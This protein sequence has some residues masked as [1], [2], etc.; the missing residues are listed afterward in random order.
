[1]AIASKGKWLFLPVAIKPGACLLRAAPAQVA[2]AAVSEPV[3]E[4]ATLCAEGNI[5]P[6]PWALTFLLNIVGITEVFGA[7][8][9]PVL[10]VPVG[11]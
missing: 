7:G 6:R 10:F 8:D 1:M 5:P 9:L 2:T 3:C 11:S 4:T